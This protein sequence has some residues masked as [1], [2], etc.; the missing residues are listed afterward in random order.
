[1]LKDKYGSDSNLVFDM[2]CFSIETSKSYQ[3]TLKE[4]SLRNKKCFS[5]LIFKNTVQ[6]FSW[7]S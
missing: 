5:F 7:F 4:Q 6:P 1:M 2:D 3:F